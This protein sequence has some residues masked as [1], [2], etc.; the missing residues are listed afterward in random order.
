MKGGKRGADGPTNEMEGWAEGSRVISLAARSVPHFPKVDVRGTCQLM[1][2]KV[3]FAKRN[4]GSQR[5]KSISNFL[6]GKESSRK[7][8]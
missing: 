6:S 3:N 2:E 5:P 4:L 7:R 1:N 8:N